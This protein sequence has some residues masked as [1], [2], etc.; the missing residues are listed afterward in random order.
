[1]YVVQN[2]MLFQMIPLSINLNGSFSTYKIEPTSSY[3]LFFKQLQLKI[4][5]VKMV[6]NY[7]CCTEFHALSNDTTLDQFE[8]V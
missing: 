1:M 7:V 8:W 3:S 4:E 6:E 2:F 5:T